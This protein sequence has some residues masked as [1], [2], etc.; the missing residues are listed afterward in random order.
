MPQMKINWGFI[1]LLA[2]L[3]AAAWIFADIVMYIILAMVLSGIL[4]VPTNA[5][6]QI[7]V[8]G[9]RIPR[10]IAILISFS[11]LV[12]VLALFVL[13]FMP[14]INEQAAVIANIPYDEFSDKL[15]LPIAHVE[16]FLI[17]SKIVNQPR[18]F[19]II[20]F[21]EKLGEIFTQFKLGNVLND[22]LLTTGNIFIGILAVL[23]ITF[24]LLFEKGKVRK[25]LIALIPNRY[26][27]VSISAI[28]KIE[29]LLSNYLLGLLL[30]IIS[31]FTIVS[32]SLILLGVNY[33]VT[34]GIFAAI[35]NVIP[36]A[37][38][39]IGTIFGVIVGISTAPPELLEGNGYLFLL[40]QL[41]LAFIITQVIDNVILQPIIFSKSV[42]AHPL[43]IFISVFAGATIGGVLG[44]LAA[45]PA[46]TVIK[47]SF[48]EIRKGFREYK[49]FK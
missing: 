3:L 45:I 28:H 17:N 18:G 22:L 12:G 26:F 5:I 46:Y 33:A 13:L 21:K 34:I 20:Q 48:L 7:Q 35:A 31:I 2:G 40:G 42:K 24:F 1:A 44:M 14:L 15:S 39:L 8:R 23:F 37:G 41:L 29:R 16:D 6:S 19:L 36:F 9:V 30:Q 4:K 47:V 43:E 27:E 38:P 49:V 32:F 10:S 25:Q 11:I